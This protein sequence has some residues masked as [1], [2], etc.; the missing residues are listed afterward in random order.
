MEA[1]LRVV[2]TQYINQG[3]IVLVCQELLKW[4]LTFC[5]PEANLIKFLLQIGVI[6]EKIGADINVLM[7]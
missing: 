6:Y 2:V 1:F 5:P 7:H 3:L 4:K